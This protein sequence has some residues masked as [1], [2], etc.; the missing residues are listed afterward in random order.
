MSCQNDRY[1]DARLYAQLVCS[2]THNP[3]DEPSIN[4][5]LNFVAGSI[6]AA[7]AASDQCSCTWAGWAENYIA[8]LN[9]YLAAALQ[10]CPC[11]QLSDD[12]KNRYLEYVNGELEKIRTG[13]ISLCAGDTAK[14]YPAIG[15]INIGWN[16]FAQ[17]DIIEKREQRE[18]F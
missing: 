4:Q 14:T 15:I 1:A 6:T 17:A 11:S 8:T 7:I 18:G 16:K 3:E 12:D 13:E 5:R 9:V 10:D 2:R